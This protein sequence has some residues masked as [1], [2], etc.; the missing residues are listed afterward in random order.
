MKTAVVILNWNTKDF[1]EKFLPPLLDSMPEGAETIVADSASEDGSRE[2]LASRFPQV[3]TVL[4]DKNYGFTGGYNRA[5]EAV[6]AMEGG[7]EMEYFVLINSDIEVGKGWLEPLVSWMDSHKDCA[8]CA[9]KLHSYF[10]KESFEYAGAAGGLLDR[11]GY[12]FCRGRV[13]KRVEKD[14]GQYDS[15]ADV[16]WATGACLMVR[17][18]AY[19]EVGG[20][21]GRFFAHMEEIDLCWRF[22][23]EG[24]R[25]SV[26]PASVVSH[27]GGGTLPN[28]SPWKLKL[29]YRNNLLMLQNNLALTYSLEE[30][31]ELTPEKAAEKA[32][33][34]ASRT[35]RFR[36]MLDLMSAAVYLL[37]GRKDCF[38]AVREAHREFKD[39]G[40]Q[41]GEEQVREYVSGHRTIGVPQLYRGWIVAESLVEGKGIFDHIR[42]RI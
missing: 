26:V 34:R 35:L 4:L 5:F 40:R 28:D 37:T 8:A 23:L 21:D 36:K 1:L 29:N 25:I 38:N 17:R 39:L 18:S 16:F 32:L 9:P 3:R 12:P 31:R 14:R 10:D 15:P 7:E 41:P 11:F 30:I 19:S 27:V 6:C 2:L 42:K 24:W 20:L 22:Q 13:M 33:K